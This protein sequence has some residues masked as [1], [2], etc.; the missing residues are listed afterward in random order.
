MLSFHFFD[1]RIN[2]SK[3]WSSNLKVIHIVMSFQCIENIYRI[4]F[5]WDMMMTILV[6]CNLLGLSFTDIKSHQSQRKYSRKQGGERGWLFYRD[7]YWWAHWFQHSISRGWPRILHPPSPPP[8]PQE[9]TSSLNPA[10][11]YQS[12]KRDI[13][14]FFSRLIFDTKE[15]VWLCKWPPS[16]T[17]TRVF[18]QSSVITDFLLIRFISILKSFLSLSYLLQND[19]KKSFPFSLL[20]DLK[21]YVP[22][23]YLGWMENSNKKTI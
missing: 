10:C 22:H 3:Y 8:L 15:V 9:W 20:N 14:F 21:V 4:D 23:L 11:H 1:S 7:R 5:Y 2:E 6:K 18:T 13:F 16:L 19:S 17:S 12:S